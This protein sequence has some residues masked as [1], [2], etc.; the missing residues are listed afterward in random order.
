MSWD[1]DPFCGIDKEMEENSIP[2][3]CIFGFHK[4]KIID[5]TDFRCGTEYIK[6]CERCGE[7]RKFFDWNNND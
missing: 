2:F 6:K 3:R 4:W 5:I 1:V 7:E